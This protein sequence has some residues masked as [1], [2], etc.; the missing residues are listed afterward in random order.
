M[1]HSKARRA[2]RSLSPA[3]HWVGLLKHVLDDDERARRAELLLSHLTIWLVV[4]GAVVVTM[5][6]L[7]ASGPWWAP[8]G[9]GGVGFLSAGLAWWRRR[10]LANEVS[11]GGTCP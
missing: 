11:T 9:A 7:L 10:R 6:V 8:A 1:S 5:A 3:A 2:S 4:L